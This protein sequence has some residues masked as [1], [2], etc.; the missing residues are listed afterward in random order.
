V[1]SSQVCSSLIRL[2]TPF[3]YTLFSYLKK[4]YPNKPPQVIELEITDYLHA[5]DDERH[6]TQRVEEEENNCLELKEDHFQFSAV[7]LFASSSLVSSTAAVERS[8]KVQGTIH[9]KLRNRLTAK[10]RI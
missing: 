7:S 3:D 6:E 1:S 9:T 8:L 10:V 5:I 2:N 4:Q